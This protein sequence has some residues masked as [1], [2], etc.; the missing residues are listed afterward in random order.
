MAD[1]IP[2]LNPEEVDNVFNLILDRARNQGRREVFIEHEDLAP[3]LTGDTDWSNSVSKLDTVANKKD[4]ARRNNRVKTKMVRKLAEKG[5]VDI[6]FHENGYNF[7]IDKDIK[8]ESIVNTVSESTFEEHKAIETF[9]NYDTPFHPPHHFPDLLMSIRRGLSPL[10][11]GPKGCGK[12]RSF[13]EAAAILGLPH[14][15]IALG[16]VHDPADLIG[17]KEIVEENGVPV[18]KFQPGLITEA[19]KKGWMV[20]L[21]ELDSVQAQVALALNMV[22]ENKS[23]IACMTE[24]GIEYVDRHPNARIVAS[25]NTWGFG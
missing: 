13:E 23:R 17:T 6:K 25:A 8:I 3:L 18:T 12:S 24:R 15:R 22:L 2:N 14:I 9:T 16:Q 11:V 1:K 19:L 20:I 10:Q 4:I 7:I 5:I 21:D